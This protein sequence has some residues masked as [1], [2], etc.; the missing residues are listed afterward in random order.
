MRRRAGQAGACA[1]GLRACAPPL[2][3]LR[4]GPRT[5]R[6]GPSGKRLPLSKPRPAPT[7]QSGAKGK[8]LRPTLAAA[9][10]G[11]GAGGPL[12]PPRQDGKGKAL[13]PR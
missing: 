5:L 11:M 6:I 10:I 4:I 12:F 13:R 3:R 2:A 7:R 8:A 9:F 1:S